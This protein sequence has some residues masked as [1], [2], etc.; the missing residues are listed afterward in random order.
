MVG[1]RRDAFG[2]PQGRVVHDALKAWS[3]VVWTGRGP[4]SSSLRLGPKDGV[5]VSRRL[6]VL[7]FSAVFAWGPVTGFPS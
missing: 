2:G 6:T 4:V 1:R 7:G 5:S 3:V